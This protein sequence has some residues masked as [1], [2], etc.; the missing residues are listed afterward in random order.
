MKNSQ[1]LDDPK[2]LVFA[3]A[4]IKIDGPNTGRVINVSDEELA[5]EQGITIEQLKEARAKVLA[6]VYAY[7]LSWPDPTSNIND[8]VETS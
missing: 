3:Q 6:R 2:Q 8:H 1:K 5:T 7:I 4:T